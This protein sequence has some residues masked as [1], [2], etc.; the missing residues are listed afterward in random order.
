MSLPQNEEDNKAQTDSKDGDEKRKVKS[1]PQ[2]AQKVAEGKKE[3]CGNVSTSAGQGLLQKAPTLEEL[4]R[5]LEELH[6]MTE[7]THLLRHRNSLNIDSLSGLTKETLHKETRKSADL[8]CYV[9]NETD[10]LEVEIPRGNSSN[11]DS[12]NDVDHNKSEEVTSNKTTNRAS[13]QL[14]PE[15]EKREDD[16]ETVEEESEDDLVDDDIY[17]D[18]LAS[19]LSEEINDVVRDTDS[20]SFENAAVSKLQPCSDDNQSSSFDDKFMGKVATSTGHHSLSQAFMNKDASSS[21]RA[22]LLHER[23]LS[24]DSRTTSLMSSSIA[25]FRRPVSH[26]SVDNSCFELDHSAQHSG[27][28]IEKMFVKSSR[29][30]PEMSIHDVKIYDESLKSS[31]FDGVMTTSEPSVSNAAVDRCASGVSASCQPPSFCLRCAIH[32]GSSKKKK[33]SKESEVILAEMKPSTSYSEQSENVVLLKPQVENAEGGKEANYDHVSVKLTAVRLARSSKKP[34]Y[35]LA[36]LDANESHCS[37]EINVRKS[38]AV[39]HDFS[40]ES[41]EPFAHLHII[42][43]E[44]TRSK[45]ARPVGKVSLR[46]TEIANAVDKEWRMKLSAVSKYPEF[47]GQICVDLRR[48]EGFFSLRVIDYGGLQLKDTQQLHLLVSTLD[49]PNEFG[50][51]SIGADRRSVE[52]LEMPCVEGLLSFRMTLWQDILK[53]VNSVFHGQVRVDVDERWRSGPCKWFYLRSRHADNAKQEMDDGNDIG[54]VMIKTTHRVEHVLQLHVYRPLLDLLCASSTVQPLTASLVALIESLPKVDLGQVSKALV[55]VSPSET[56]RPLLD[57]LYENNIYKCQDENTLFRGQSL[58]GKMLFEILKTYGKSYLV[59]TLKPVIDKIFKERKNCE[60]DPSRLPP[61]SSAKD[62]NAYQANLLSYFNAVFECVTQSSANCPHFIKLLLADLRK[63]VAEKKGRIEME[64]LALSSFVIMRFFAAAVLS[65]RAFDIRKEQPDHRVSRTLLLLSKMLQRVAN[66]TVSDRPLSQKEPWL[67]EVLE[68]VTGNE[69]KNGMTKFLDKISLAPEYEIERE[70]V[71][72]F[73]F[74]H[75]QQV[76]PTR[77]GWKKILQAKKRYIQL[78][79]TQLVWQKDSQSN[80]KGYLMLSDIKS[81]TADD[82]HLITITTDKLQMHFGSASASDTT[83][84]LAAIEKQRKRIRRET[85]G[86]TNETYVS[87]IE[88]NLDVIHCILYKYYDTMQQW[89]LDLQSW[90]KVDK[91]SM[92]EILKADYL[93]AEN[94]EEHRLKLAE[95]LRNT[96]AVSQTIQKVHNEYEELQKEKNMTKEE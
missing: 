56:L 77:T 5:K 6:E 51:L 71:T 93:S 61:G 21:H 73:K 92:P 82:K 48:R 50:K 84:W 11:C 85:F 58:A 79:D 68:L 8:L 72:V 26:F 80:P 94:R 35:I 90:E 70:T 57:T 18:D 3:D 83:E 81:V 46:R 31:L 24:N 7:V 69:Y 25:S 75:L 17:Y 78:T 45:V 4:D 63:V 29:S 86:L 2:N 19:V 33:T 15:T 32:D 38:D 10:E 39:L 1:E 30:A 62:K 28:P 44:G 91:K 52:W 47:C 23:A 74:G 65:P 37:P 67:S 43:F 89:S 16:K 66:C 20:G 54:E 14:V 87:D 22:S 27:T 53:G 60:V 59:I 40:L 42:F 9:V 96:L 41:T 13:V 36:K 76:D 49:N 55:E 64:R 88:R 34:L 12:K 95:T